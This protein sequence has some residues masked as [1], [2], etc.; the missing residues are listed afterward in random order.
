MKPKK[1]RR[2]LSFSN[3]QK[4][5]GFLFTVPF[6]IGFVFFFARPFVQAIIL[7]FNELVLTPQTFELQWRG[8]ENYGYALQVHPEFSRI[9]SEVLI[10]LVTE[11]PLIIGFSF[12]AATILNSDFKGRT[13]VRTLF[14]LPVIL[15]AG[16]V[17]KMEVTD[18]SQ[19]ML[20]HMQENSA[21]VGGTALRAFFE[22]ARFPGGM[23]DFVI[24]AI[25]ALPTVIRASGVQ[26]LIFLAGLQSI[27][28]DIYEAA[29]VEGATGWERFWL[30][31]FPMM[32]P[33]IM[34]N[35]IYTI[36][37]SF[38]AMNNEL[39]DLIRET[40]LRGAGYGVSMAMAMLYFLVIGVILLIVFVILSRRVFYQV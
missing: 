28:R 22:T 12:F 25:Q 13:I 5:G 16:V 9:F 19:I 32:T 17:M 1:K 11:L 39:V 24:D 30:I 21:F 18:Y 34:T 37:D 3:R 31:T 4:L 36:I 35:I 33:L 40:M 26:I 7:S 10:K 23:V 2:Q 15:G 20:Q 29:S 8:W 14:F 6:L 38:T 27:P